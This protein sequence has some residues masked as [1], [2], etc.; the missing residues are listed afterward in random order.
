MEFR[1]INPAN[2]EVL[3]SFQ[4]HSSEDVGDILNFSH[5]VFDD[6]RA[7][8]FEK[9]ASL[10]TN[11]AEK[12]R[13]NKEEYAQLITLEMGKILNESLAEIEKC[14]WVCEYY[15]TNGYSFLADENLNLSD[16][17]VIVTYEPLGC[18]LGIMPWNFPFWQVFR[19]VVPAIMAGNVTL[20]K[21]APNVFGCALAIEQLFLDAGFPKSVFQT[22]II[23][24]DE[25]DSVIESDKVHAITLTGSEGAGKSVA[26]KAGYSIKKTVLELGGSDAFIVLSDADLIKATEIA[27]QSRMLNSGQSCIAAKRFIVVTSVVD[28]FT[29][30]LKQN[31]QSLMMGNPMD[32]NTDFG[33][34]AR[35]DLAEKLQDQV[36]KSIELGARLILGG[37]RGE[38]AYFP[39]TVIANVS[40]GMPAYNEELFGP[41]A[42]IIEVGN[43]DQ[44][45]AVA[46]DT[47]Y[48]LGASVWT[49]DPIKAREV[50]RKIEAGAVFINSMV[51][52]DPRIPFG[53]IKNSGYG[54]ELSSFG[55]R[56]F[57]NVKPIIA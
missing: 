39:A 31:M 5:K 47:S 1:S 22:L 10:F 36:D 19:F 34:L 57:V 30:L 18:V 44:A 41:V 52:S 13:S 16:K 26:A 33:P 43:S 17:E 51:A 38:G 21:H 42:S 32:P 49:S 27:V 37:T 12:L 25:I 40:K 20:L 55:I 56:E 29:Q 35:I 15:A 50:A 54:R 9:R 4:A 6:W 8:S 2:G 46:N 23:H 24:S 28:E 45:I 3:C 11:C 14:A 53:G 7:T 48:G